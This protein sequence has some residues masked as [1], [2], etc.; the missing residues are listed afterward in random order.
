MSTFSPSQL[1][2]KKID[3]T[4]CDKE[5]IHI[6][7][8]IQKRGFLLTCSFEERKLLRYSQNIVDLFS[9]GVDAIFNEPIEFLFETHNIDIHAI[10]NKLETKDVVYQEVHI[11]KAPITLITHK[12]AT[13]YIIE[14]EPNSIALNPFEYQLQLSEIAT[15]IN[16]EKNIS[17]KCNSAARLI[18]QYLGYDR[19]MIYQFDADWNGSIIAESK[20]EHL[21]SWLGLHYPSTDIPQ[22]ARKLFLKQ[23]VRIIDDVNEI[24]TPIITNTKNIDLPPLDLSKSELRAV[25]PIHIEYLQNMKVGATLTAAIVFN[26]T[27]WGLIACHH[28]S[29]KFINFYQRLSCKFLAQIFSTSLQLDSKNNVL[30]QI[31]KS[32]ITRSVLID[33]ITREKDIVL[34]LSRFDITLNDLTHSTGAA[35]CIDNDITLIGTCPE[36]EQIRDLINFISE[37]TTENF[38]QTNSISR[39]F[40]TA[41]AY[42]NIASGVLC[43]FISKAKKDALI[44]FKPEVIQNVDWAGNPEKAVSIDEDVHLSPRKSF[45]KWSIEQ[46]G[47]S[48]PWTDNEIAAVK[49]LNKSI[50]D[51]IIEK[52]NEV[53]ELNARLKMAYDELESFSYSVSHDLRAPLRG[54]DGFAHIIKEEYF[55]S[56][57]DFGKN[58]VKTIIDSVE[59]MN[60]L[61][62]DILEYSGLGKKPVEYRHF[63]LIKLT[64]D[65]L[66]DLENIYPNVQV[67]IQEAMPDLKGD[68][69]ITTLL[70]KNL[71]ENAMKYSSKKEKPLVNIG[72]L[73]DTIYYIKDNG[74]GF[75]MKHQKTIFGVF[76]RLVND[77]YSGSG[78]GL[79]IAKRVVDK[80]KGKIWVESKLNEGTTFYFNLKSHE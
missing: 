31:Q 35:I 65:L 48:E 14:L 11:N 3:L 6:I 61:I 52:Y 43:Q 46:E 41:K 36:I 49:S 32:S 55:D 77:E 13:E 66:V 54:I 79:A 47:I 33:Q 64:K 9:I 76:N 56:L 60:T 42:K 24:S 53:K 62:D 70:I 2:P 69:T 38:Y 45:E 78:I 58:S 30:D 37:Q 57:D 25:S 22:Q 34:G 50:S 19:V 12:N 21:E 20:E 10:L 72:H 17:E 8:N 28:Y 40:E 71:L 67:E 4:N 75:D 73:K 1:Y 15:K 51:I 5:P 18:K 59:K 44:W 7:G 29:Q 39:A 26:D 68:K 63:S 16:T 80:H 74:I 27:L 23:G